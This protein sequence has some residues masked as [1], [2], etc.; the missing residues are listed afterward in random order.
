LTPQRNPGLSKAIEFIVERGKAC[1]GG[2]KDER[3]FPMQLIFRP[4][5]KHVIAGA[6]VAY[7]CAGGCALAW[8]Q[9]VLYSFKG[10]SSDGAW[11][12]S[13]LIMNNS[14]ALFG[15]TVEGGI[16]NCGN[17]GYTGCGTVFE[18]TKSGGIW[19]EK[20]IHGF[21]GGT[22]DG[23]NPLGG[24]II[25]TKTGIL[26]GTTSTGGAHQAGTIFAATAGSES[27]LYSFCRRK[28]C[29]DGRQPVAGLVESPAQ[30]LYGTTLEGGTGKY[31][32]SAGGNCGT[33]F[34][35]NLATNTENVI[36]DFV[37]GE[38]DA[39]DGGYPSA[40]L[41]RDSK[42]S[43]YGTTLDGG[44]DVGCAP[45]GC[46]TV[47]ELS[48]S[49]KSWKETPLYRFCPNGIA[50]CSDGAYPLANVIG[51]KAAVTYLYGTTWRGGTG[52]SGTCEDP[53]N[54][55]GVVFKLE[56]AKPN[57]E[58]VLYS[59]CSTTGCPDGNY[60]AGGVLLKNGYLYGTTE[61]G[62]AN[63]KGTVFQISATTGA[64]TVLYSF[65][66]QA[67][68]ADGSTPAAGLIEDSAGNLYG[69]TANGGTGNCTG[70]VGC[71]T[72]FEISS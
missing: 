70:S 44:N 11:P 67:N 3:G 4:G 48:T 68:C 9:S 53:E 47:F 54:N 30:I 61:Q 32:G 51:D 31:C 10:G 56:T 1:E 37:E 35:Y 49:G 24:L 38:S 36:H 52:L 33:A 42:G 55:C 59:F 22:K 20:L 19:T 60:V 14:G 25:D 29:E 58:T 7:M 23:A 34:S 45:Y 15:T 21:A 26:Y 66:S 62:G 64:E 27:L 46:G 65:C 2:E 39:S 40:S 13:K 63:G 17:L 18:L 69:T 12:Y 72:I 28:D 5:G 16:G 50:H 8:N 57:T 43:L 6:L 71:G 41:V